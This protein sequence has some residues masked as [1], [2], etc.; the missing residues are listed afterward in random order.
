MFVPS[1][2]HTNT[3]LH[4]MV[5]NKTGF[6]LRYKKIH[7]NKYEFNV[8]KKNRASCLDVEK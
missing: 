4:L 2:K 5:S 8:G 7:N 6:Y 1:F 3:H